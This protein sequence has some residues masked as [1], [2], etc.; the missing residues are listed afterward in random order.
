M[1]WGYRPVGI[2]YA[3]AFRYEADG[4]FEPDVIRWGCSVGKSIRVGT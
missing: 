1:K 3:L 2:S 4:F